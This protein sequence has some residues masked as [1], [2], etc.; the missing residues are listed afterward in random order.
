M[1]I[2][3]WQFS[4]RYQVDREMRTADPSFRKPGVGSA[5]CPHFYN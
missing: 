2:S 3:E 4:T 1:A 5:A